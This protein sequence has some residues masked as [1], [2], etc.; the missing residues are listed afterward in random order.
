MSRRGKAALIAAVVAVSAGVLISQVSGT[1]GRGARGIPGSPEDAGPRGL[2]ALVALLDATGHDVRRIG[3]PASEADL[4]PEA[5]TVLISPGTLT[6]GDAE[7]LADVAAEGGRVVVAG[8]PGDKALE[9]L[10]ETQAKIEPGGAASQAPL[11]VAPETAGVAQIEGNEPAVV[12]PAGSALP[13]TG[14]P[15]SAGVVATGAGEG[16]VIVAADASIFENELI[17]LEDN[18]RFALNLAGATGRHVQLIEAVRTP[19]ASGLAALPAA[20]GWA[21]GGLL[22]GALALAW[23]RGRRLDLDGAQP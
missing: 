8:D 21:A 10:L 17:V 14:A 6:A 9:A 18:A 5:T 3:D 2:L 15:G 20:W 1:D 19:P 7:A 16:R 11:T 22:L 12:D 13:I 4:D 23:S